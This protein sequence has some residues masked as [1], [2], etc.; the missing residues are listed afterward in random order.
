MKQIKPLHVLFIILNILGI[1]LEYFLLYKYLFIGIFGFSELISFISSG[2]VF[3]ALTILSMISYYKR[4]HIFDETDDDQIDQYYKTTVEKIKKDFKEKQKSDID[5]QF[6][7][8]VIQPS[9][10]FATQNIVYINTNKR[11][12]FKMIDSAHFKGVLT[13]ELGHVVHMPKIYLLANTRLTGI[14]GSLFLI[15]TY[16]MSE[17]LTKKTNKVLNRII[18]G[19]IYLLFIITNLLNLFILYPFKRY[20]EIM[21]D[22]ISLKFDNGY[23]LRGFYAKLDKQSNTK[24]KKFRYKFID[25][26][27]LPPRKH[28]QKLDKSMIN[29]DN[30]CEIYDHHNIY[31]KQY[32]DKEDQTNQILDFYESNVD[33]DI[34]SMYLYIAKKYEVVN[35]L[36][37]AKKYF[38]LAGENNYISG[39]RN[40]ARILAKENDLKKTVLVYQLLADKG[41]IEAKIILE[42][43]EQMYLL[44]QSKVDDEKTPYEK[45]PISLILHI[46]KTYECFINNDLIKGKFK[47]IKYQIIIDK[48]IKHQTRFDLI[49]SEIV[50]KVYA[51]YEAKSDTSHKIIDYYHKIKSGD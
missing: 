14:L 50:S 11:Y 33:K 16:R 38:R 3:V 30:R 23:A 19:F 5:I 7:D 46:N 28:Y 20:E 39:Y 17:L 27:H 15:F 24:I 35:H 13:H 9:T 32:K 47:R 37:L 42:Y 25:F 51:L 48:P 8:G 44:Y 2:F 36:A 29:S 10:M 49:N 31:V 26:N 4:K 43:Y 41:D 21:A 12:H 40:L 22:K 1:V 34:I 6:V 18:F 45:A